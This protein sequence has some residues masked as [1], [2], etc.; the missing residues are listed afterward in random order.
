M[1]L[2]RGGDDVQQALGRAT[3]L[4]ALVELEQANPD[5]CVVLCAVRDEA[6]DIVDFECI[7]SN[8]VDVM[9]RVCPGLVVGRRLSE[10]PE[11]MRGQFALFRQVVETRRAARSE[12]HDTGCCLH[13]T[14]LPLLDGVLVRFQDVTARVRDAREREARLEQEQSGRRDAEALARVQA[15]QLQV[16]QEKLVRSGNLMAAGQLAT[17]VGHEINNPLAFV[18]GNLHVALEQLGALACE[19]PPSA[20]ERL[21]ETA[22]ALEDARKGAERIRLIVRELRTLA[23]ASDTLSEPVDVGAALELSLSMAMPHIRHRAQVVR[24]VVPVPRVPGN[25]SKLGQVLLNLLINAAQA[26]PE[27]DAARH[28]ITVGTRM[29]GTRVVIEV[30]DTGKGMSAE[31]LARIFEPFFTT[32]LPGEGTGLGLPISLDIIRSMGGEMKVQSEPGRGSTFQLVLPVLDEATA[33]EAG[34]TVVKHQAPPRRRVLIVDD[35]PAIGTMMVRVLGRH[36][37]VKV[38]HSGR[39]ALELL[40]GDPGYD[41]VFCDLMMGDMTGM[42]LHAALTRRRPEYLPRVTF[43][44]GGAFTDRARAFLAEASVESIEKPFEASALRERVE[45]PL[46]GERRRDSR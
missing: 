5:G 27:G 41:R 37:E 10:A 20:A 30:R 46:P 25:E 2:R 45:R 28:T 43:M 42:D 31:V 11:A 4:R 1:P 16:A 39:E 7:F 29:E 12:L 19:L 17:G 3:L 24:H 21:R 40:C 34:S 33:P 14:V 36:H 6:Q 26:I 9:K 44:T 23:R 18:T 38:V 32:K 22:Q 13:G 8:D 35:E 15:G